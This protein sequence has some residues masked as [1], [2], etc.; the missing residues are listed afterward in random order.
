MSPTA[1]QNSPPHYRVNY[2]RLIIEGTSTEI[3]YLF[4]DRAIH[5]ATLQRIGLPFETNIG[6][7]TNSTADKNTYFAIQVDSNDTVDRLTIIDGGSPLMYHK[8]SH[9]FTPED[10]K[11]MGVENPKFE[12][13]KNRDEPYTF[14]DLHGV[15]MINQRRAV[16]GSPGTLASLLET[17]RLEALGW[18]QFRKGG[19]P[20]VYKLDGK[21]KYEASP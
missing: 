21:A 5:V 3:T 9:V 6:N 8:P 17:E 19:V 18:H 15:N 7:G 1:G 20:F 16:N 2:K 12:L 10:W 14:N 13:P 11:L 4:L